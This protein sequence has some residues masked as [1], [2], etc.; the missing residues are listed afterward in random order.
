MAD[1]AVIAKP[2]TDGKRR[3]LVLVEDRLGHYAEFRAYFARVFA[4]DRVGLAE[5]GYLRAPSGLAYAL[6]FIGRSGEPFPSGVEIYAIVDAL[7]PIDEAVIDRDLWAILGWMIAGVGPP[8]SLD[9]LHAVG[10][11]YRIPAVSAAG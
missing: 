4:L 10:R 9:D 7:E 1:V 11:L 3:A 8:W 6:M 2:D 5:P